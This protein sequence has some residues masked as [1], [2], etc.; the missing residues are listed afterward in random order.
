MPNDQITPSLVQE[1][2]RFQFPEWAA[3]PIT[4]VVPG[5]WDNRT[6]RLG[7]E[8]V[9]RLPSAAEYAPQVEKEH[10]WLPKIAPFVSLPIPVPIAK[11]DS[12]D[13]YLWHW[14]IYRWIEGKPATIEGIRD[15]CQFATSLAE[16]LIS[17]QQ[18]NTTN[19]P[20]P[21]QHCFFRGAPL[22]IYTTET[23]D[24]LTVLEGV[25]DTTTAQKLWETACRTSWNRPPVWFH[26]DISAGNLLIHNGALCAIIDFGCSGIGDPACDMAI[27]WTFFSGKNREAFRNAM[28]IDEGTWTRGRAWALWKALIM[29]ANLI[30]SDSIKTEI[31]RSII[32]EI[33][34]D[35][36]SA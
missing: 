15:V 2:I 9:V 17:L 29:M 25:I 5:G 19:G 35:Y 14:S 6:F 33:L 24:A 16:F 11:G 18:A 4:P 7:E 26:G 22:G 32:N 27:A 30:H 12:N 31:Y 34:T 8:M 36:Q 21:G 3:L 20:L 10:Y 23:L 13:N 28:G 1:L